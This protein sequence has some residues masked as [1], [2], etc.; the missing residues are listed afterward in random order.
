MGG[1]ANLTV[2]RILSGGVDRD[3]MHVCFG[4]L[5]AEHDTR[6]GIAGGDDG[7]KWSRG[8]S[9]ER[10]FVGDGLRDK[11]MSRVDRVGRYTTCENQ[12]KKKGEGSYWLAISV[13]ELP[14]LE[15]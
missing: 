2:G 13:P 4:A 6:S 9:D 3:S 8:R 7:D 11:G 1:P 15:T 14:V 5:V 12:Q 10:E